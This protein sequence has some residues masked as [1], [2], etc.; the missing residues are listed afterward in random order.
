MAGVWKRSKAEGRDLL[1]MLALADFANDEGKSWPAVSTLAG[2]A[3]ISKRTCQY[4]LTKLAET[5]EIEV[6]REAGPHGTNLYTII[7]G[8]GCKDCMGGASVA[9]G[10]VQ[11][12]L[13]GGGATAIAPEPS[14]NHQEVEVDV[15]LA[16]VKDEWNRIA[17]ESGLQQVRAIT[18]GRAKHLKARLKDAFFSENW[19]AAMGRVAQSDFCRGL[20]GRGWTATFDWFLK[21]DVVAKV[22]EGA[23]D[24][25]AGYRPNRPPAAVST[26]H[27]IG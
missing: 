18:P 5:G 22:I 20:T 6:E 23:Y 12:L 27:E 16:A 13:H 21:P 25:R 1:V 15:S 14:M 8:G 7:S 26:Q 9:R 4:V 11:Q 17:K 10:G 19:R 2:K 3:R 24:N